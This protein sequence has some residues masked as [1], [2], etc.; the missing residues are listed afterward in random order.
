MLSSKN[1]I[2]SGLTFRFSIH[3]EFIFAYSI[4]ECSN[5]LLLH[6]AV[7]FSQ[8]HLLKRP[9]LLHRIFL[10]CLSQISWPQVCE[11]I[12]GLSSLFHWSIF[13]F[14]CQ[15]HTIMTTLDLYWTS[16]KVRLSFS[17]KS[18]VT[19]FSANSIIYSEVRESNFSSSVFLS[20]DCFGY[21]GSSVSPYNFKTFCSSSVKNAISNLIGIAL[22]L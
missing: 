11:F 6:I 12:S 22:N 16:Q 14:L 13:L 7:Q 4:K 15:C 5:F 1:L 9:P 17:I 2:V 20:Q 19:N 3:F 10:P 8:H 21:L 18:Y